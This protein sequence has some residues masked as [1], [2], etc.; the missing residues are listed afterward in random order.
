MQDTGSFRAQIS[1]RDFPEAKRL[2]RWREIFGRR[3]TNADIEPIGDAPFH[4][5]VTF[6][7]LPNISIA[8][9]SH[10]PAH[11]R[12]S[13]EMASRGRNIVVIG[14]L[15]SGA[16]SSTQFGRELI[17]GVGN[18]L[19]LTPHAPSTTT[20]LTE[21]NFI[22]LTFEQPA[23][24][25]LAP[26]YAASFGSIPPGSAALNLLTRYVD[27]VRNDDAFGEPALVQTV[28]DHILDLA[29]L[30]LGASGDYAE[31]ARQRSATVARLASIKSDILHALSRSDLSTEMI[32]ARHGI[33]PRYVRKLFEQS[34]SSFS[35]FVLA[36]R[37]A[38]A[39][40]MVIDRRCHHLNIAQI[41]HESGFGDVSY[42]NRVFRRHFGGT[43]SDFRETARLSW[44][45]REE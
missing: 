12:V 37:L 44:R 9:G 19:A 45:E 11:Y 1:T 2:E 10:S 17:G 40:R 7:L 39:Q 18:A 41:A 13:K 36:E 24:A 27:V 8:A 33:S 3:M 23:L 35:G 22:T 16:A 43:P 14:L 30:T 4:A 6:T 21:G 15:R 42:F 29:A 38:K 26:N 20:I 28:S 25:A 32:A 34:G 31:I 5:D